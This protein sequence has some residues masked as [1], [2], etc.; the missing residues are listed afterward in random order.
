[1]SVGEIVLFFGCRHREKDELFG[2]EFRDLA[3]KGTLT[4]YHC[5]FSRDQDRKVYVQHL[6]AQQ[7]AQI[8]PLLVQKRASIF[9]CGYSGDM[10]RDV[11]LAF[12]SILQQ[13]GPMDLASALSFLQTMERTGRYNTETWS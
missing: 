13:E 1:L 8:V 4:A 9:V 12:L 2:S 10:P 11:R 6:I 7:A 5:A 3:E